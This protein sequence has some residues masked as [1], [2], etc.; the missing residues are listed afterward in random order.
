MIAAGHSSSITTLDWSEDGSVLRSASA[1]YEV[2]HWD[3]EGKLVLQDQR[4]VKWARLA[5]FSAC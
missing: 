4:D 1:D 3:P 2:M 5:T